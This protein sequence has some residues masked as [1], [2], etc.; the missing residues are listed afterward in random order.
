MEQQPAHSSLS[1]MFV[2][3]PPTV[4]KYSQFNYD[5]DSLA[6]VTTHLKAV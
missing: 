2:P 6:K 3:D 1:Y 5:Y 4:L